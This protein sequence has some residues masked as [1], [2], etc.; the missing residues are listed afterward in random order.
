MLS[1]TTEMIYEVIV[2]PQAP[3]LRGSFTLEQNYVE[4]VVNWDSSRYVFVAER[5]DQGLDWID[6]VKPLLY[7]SIIRI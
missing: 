2:N 4:K 6:M 1:A 7:G 3:E 5:I